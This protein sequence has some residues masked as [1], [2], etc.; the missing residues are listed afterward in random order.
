LADDH[1]EILRAFKRL[2]EPSC[3][4]VGRVTD[5]LTLLE[6]ASKLRP[7]VI[8]LDFNM[9]GVDGLDACARIKRTGLLSKI[10]I[11]SAA[12]DESIRQRALNVG[13]SAFVLKQRAVQDLCQAIQ[14]AVLEGDG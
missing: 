13:A 8:V 4:V 2:I 6:E 10:V 3:E 9:P 7:D 12:N 14:R 5:G 1:E 11:V